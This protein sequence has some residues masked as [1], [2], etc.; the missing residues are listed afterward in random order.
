MPEIT[1]P[2]KSAVRLEISIVPPVIRADVMP[3]ELQMRLIHGDVWRTIDPM[4]LGE[5][6]NV[7]LGDL[8]PLTLG[9]RID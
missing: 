5:M 8:D 3:G 2:Y 1:F 9:G 7:R 6:D 4:R